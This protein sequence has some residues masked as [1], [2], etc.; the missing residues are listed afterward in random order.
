MAFKKSPEEYRV[1]FLFYAMPKI[2]L[3]KNQIVMLAIG[4]A[5]LLGLIILFMTGGKNPAPVAVNL[6]VWGVDD[7]SVFTTALSGY[8][9]PAS[10]RYKK[11][12]EDSYRAT[13]LDA[14]AA[15]EGPDV[16]MVRGEDLYKYRNKTVPAPTSTIS[17]AVMD[18]NFPTAVIQEYTDMNGQAWGLP[19]SLD[20]LALF[21]NKDAL[22]QAGIVFPPANWEDF[23]ADVRILAKRNANNQLVSPAAGI[24]GT[25]STVPIG[26]D[27]LMALMMQNGT[28]M[29]SKDGLEATFA[30]SSEGLK[31]FNYYLQF[32]NPSS[33][34]Y[35]WNENLGSAPSLFAGGRLPLYFGYREDYLKL[36]AAAPY[37][38]IKVA[39]MPQAGEYAVNYPR[40][41]G[42]AVSKQSKAPSY[43]WD[44]V[45]QMA[46][47]TNGPRAYMAASGR[48]PA[49]KF[50]MNEKKGDLDLGVFALQGLTAR[51]WRQPDGD[52]VRTILS[53]AI[54]NVLS[55][56]R[57]AQ[58]ALSEAEGSINALYKR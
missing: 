4:A 15:G 27:V 57:D 49:I 58:R 40:T 25:L 1:I 8:V 12:P 20:T 5:M 45:I 41:W 52:A 53:D 29:N 3:T 11:I 26:T 35:T 54:S 6:T 31:A 33:P 23:Q 10:V 24:G 32:A 14:L 18:S 30:K 22:E 42:L 39:P 7:E 50:L 55:G 48:P 9:G 43:A 44:F 21:Y 51:A 19:L 34:Y 47:G 38:A 37:L 46:G 28:T 13:L 17:A 36:K 56:A 16:F 2:N